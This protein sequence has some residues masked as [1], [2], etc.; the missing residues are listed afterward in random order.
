MKKLFLLAIVV[1]GFTAVSFAQPSVGNA[2]AKATIKAAHTMTKVNDL[3][4]GTFALTGVP[5]SIILAADGTPGIITGATGLTGTSGCSFTLGGGTTEA[6]SVTLPGMIDITTGTG[7]GET[8]IMH[9][10]NWSTNASTNAGS[11]SSLTGGAYTLRLG[12]KLNFDG[13]EIAG[14]YTGIFALT[15]VWK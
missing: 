9:V 10:D 8:R 4:F 15:V 6:F 1:L 13:N 3:N 7:I 2:D 14:D 12:G 5:G 11:P